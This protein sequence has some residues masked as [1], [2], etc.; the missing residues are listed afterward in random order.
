MGPGIYGILQLIPYG[1]QQDGTATSHTGW[2]APNPTWT[3][4]GPHLQ[5][6][7]PRLAPSFGFTLRA[8]PIF[9]FFSWYLST[10]QPMMI[11]SIVGSWCMCR[12]HFTL[13][14]PSPSRLG[15][16]P[17]AADLPKG[18]Q[19]LS[20]NLPRNP[21]TTHSALPAPIYLPQPEQGAVRQET[22]DSEGWREDGFLPQPQP[23]RLP[24]TDTES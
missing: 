18:P 17:S 16:F 1:P 20:T 2:G 24:R 21:E 15:P 3:A 8:R 5:A 14:G 11:P 4:L 6:P 10:V 13:C 9:Y 7:A 12:P 23:W 22:Q 19:Q